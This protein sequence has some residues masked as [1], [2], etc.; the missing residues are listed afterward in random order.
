MFNK[1]ITLIAVVFFVGST[2]AQTND[3]LYFVFLNTNPEREVLS[4]EKA[5][6]IQAAHMQNIDKLAEEGKLFAAGPFEGGGGMFILHAESLAEAKSF[7]QSDP[8]VQAN[9]FA[10]EVF[11]FQLAHGNMCGAKEPYEMVTYQMI[12]FT[13][14][15]KNGADEH[16]VT[17]DTRIFMA[18][19][20][21]KKKNIVAQG[22]FNDQADGILI[23][24]VETTKE[25][26]KIFKK[27]PSVKSGKMTYE[28]KT[29]W[30]AK[31]T[32]CE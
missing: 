14:I 24:N 32:F 15:D 2:M 19:V 21:A 30:I 12:R 31:G 6:A 10:T 8:A 27:H 13:N 20:G 5:E 17:H 9:R 18:D 28:V 4:D 23:L 22:Y 29:L 11:P 26:E 25:A 16:K 1:L 7:L 3:N